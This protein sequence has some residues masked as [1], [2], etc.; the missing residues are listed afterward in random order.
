MLNGCFSHDFGC[1]L[2]GEC[3]TTPRRAL[4][5]SLEDGPLAPDQAIS[6]HAS[7]GDLNAS[8]STRL[9][10]ID[11]FRGLVMALMWAPIFAICDVSS[12]LPDS[13][14]WS[15]LCYH[16]SHVPWRGISLHDLIQPGFTFLVGTA[17][18]FSISSRRR[19]GQTDS[20]LI[21]HAAWRSAVLVLLGVFLRSL[22]REQT[23]W[24]FEDTLSQI[25]LGYL[26]LVI[27]ALAPR[28]VAAVSIV[29]ILVG[30]WLAFVIYPLPP[31][32][33][34]YAAVG[35]PETWPHLQ[36]GIAAHWNKN[37]NLAWRVDTWLLN[38]F[39]RQ[40]PFTHNGGGY[41]T[42]SFIPTLATMLMGL[43]A[44]RWLLSGESTRRT[45]TRFAIVAAIGLAIG[46]LLD[47]TGV[48]P[49]VKR[50]W[51]P[52]WTLVSGAWCFVILGSLHAICDVAGYRV[53]A[54]PLVVVGM[55]SIAAYVMEWVFP[56][57]I[58]A[59]LNRHLGSGWASAIGGDVFGPSIEGL[60]VTIIVWCI[61]WWMYRRSIFIKI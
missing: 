54:F 31:E 15:F 4:L 59:N 23:Y 1:P 58:T 37:S 56:D 14:F 34:N 7:A 35:V 18:A 32:N 36:E 61:L 19:R 22:A 50:I 52:S 39:P 42:L 12:A 40:S 10:S 11:A 43:V 49:S 41:A 27:I 28:V 20:G 55:N 25:G 5:D 47:L 8:L 48:C 44:G 6:E 2:E 53:W 60:G 46:H 45:L 29:V 16:Q 26:P 9:V 57:F 17:L 33:F 3:T 13:S 51:T 38:L 24:T 21:L 30:Y